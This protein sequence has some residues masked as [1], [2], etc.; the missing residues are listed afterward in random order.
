MKLVGACS[1]GVALVL[2]P[3]LAGETKFQTNATSLVELYFAARLLGPCKQKDLALKAEAYCQ[4]PNAHS[5][6]TKFRSPTS[7]RF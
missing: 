7:L 4:P 6:H 1:A 2:E 5:S 3:N